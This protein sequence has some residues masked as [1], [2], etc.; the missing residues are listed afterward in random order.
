[1]L[2]DLPFGGNAAEGRKE[3]VARIFGDAAKVCF[4][5]RITNKR[6]IGQTAQY[7]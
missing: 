6:T 2:A 5:P 1:V 4:Y 7:L 3:P